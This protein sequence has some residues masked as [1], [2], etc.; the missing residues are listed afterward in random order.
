MTYLKY[1][2][3]NSLLADYSTEQKFQNPVKGNIN[4][5]SNT[6]MLIDSYTIFPMTLKLK[7]KKKGSKKNLFPSQIHS[8]SSFSNPLNGIIIHIFAKG[9]QLCHLPY[10]T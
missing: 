9:N 2:Q 8:F 4:A 10:L 3:I 1:V 6:A 7:K 5:K